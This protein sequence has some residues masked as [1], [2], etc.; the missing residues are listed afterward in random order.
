MIFD[1]IFFMRTQVCLITLL[2]GL[3]LPAS[4]AEEN[5]SGEEAKAAMVFPSRVLP[6]AQ[7][8]IISKLYRSKNG[9][10][11]VGER[12]HIF[13]SA[14]FKGNDFKQLETPARQ[15]LTAITG[16]GD[17]RLWAVGHDSIILYSDNGGKSFSV[18][19]FKTS[20]KF[21]SSG[22]FF[23]PLFDIVYLGGDE[24]VA[25]GA[26]GMFLRTTDGGKHWMLVPIDEEGPHFF[27]VDQAP[28]GQLFLAGEFGAVFRCASSGEEAERLNTDVESSFFGIEVISDEEWYGYGLRG[29]IYHY[30]SGSMGTIST[31]SNATIFGSL[32]HDDGILFYER[33]GDCIGRFF[34]RSNCR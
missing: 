17:Q 12:G 1:L 9:L 5:D 21:P 20:W 3:F 15:Y 26:Y 8:S 34:Y 22:E 30:Q 24:L 23:I 2:T 29:R 32:V 7:S 11:A 18:Q 28:S 14:S 27:D 6:L 19:H 10:F 33:V 25:V 4:L 13:H 16:D 31:D